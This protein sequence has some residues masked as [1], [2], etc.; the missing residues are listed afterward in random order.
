[1]KKNKKNQKDETTRI[2][3]KRYRMVFGVYLPEQPVLSIINK[4]DSFH[5]HVLDT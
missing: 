5:G 2:H 1:M 4:F 3:G